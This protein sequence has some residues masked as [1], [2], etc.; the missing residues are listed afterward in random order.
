LVF[1]HGDGHDIATV[2]RIAESAVGYSRAFAA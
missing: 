1:A 2:L